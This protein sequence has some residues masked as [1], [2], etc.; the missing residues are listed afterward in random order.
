MRKLV[1]AVLLAGGVAWFGAANASEECGPGCHN[2]SNGGCVVNG[3]EFGARVRNE[4]P[5]GTRPRRPC[6]F[7][8]VW[9]YKTCF[10]N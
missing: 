5:V 4:C 2:A 6:P 7:G 1:V 9:K 3:W 10:P 8:S